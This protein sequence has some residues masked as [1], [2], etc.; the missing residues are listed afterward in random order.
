MK[1]GAHVVF[2]ISAELCSHHHSHILK[3]F[4]HPKRNPVPITAIPLIWNLSIFL[5]VSEQFCKQQ[6]SLLYWSRQL[7]VLFPLPVLCSRFIWHICTFQLAL[8]LP[9]VLSFLSCGGSKTLGS[10]VREFA[11]LTVPLHLYLSSSPSEF[12]VGK[13]WQDKPFYSDETP[14]P[15]IYSLGIKPVYSS[16]LYQ[17]RA[18]KKHRANTYNIE[19]LKT[20]HLL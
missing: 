7:P 19:N 13:A 8:S 2:R 1:R 11:K 16:Q 4:H 5:P 9:S 14:Q 6:V 15:H 10:S 17:P 18:F 3:H 20:H 12:S